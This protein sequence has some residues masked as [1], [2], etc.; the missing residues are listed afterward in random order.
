M[1]MKP[2]EDRNSPHSFQQ[3]LESVHHSFKHGIFNHDLLVRTGKLME[4]VER[5]TPDPISQLKARCL[6]SEIYD[7]FGRFKESAEA[8]REG[9]D[10]YASLKPEPDL[11]L[12]VSLE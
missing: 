1:A 5:H 10:V 11:A 12:P 9:R 3:L 2:V 8:V 6:I 4:A 7:Y